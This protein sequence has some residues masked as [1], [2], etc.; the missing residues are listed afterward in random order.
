MCSFC[1]TATNKTGSD[2]NNSFRDLES[3]HERNV[4]IESLPSAKPEQLLCKSFI[5]KIIAAKLWWRVRTRFRYILLDNKIPFRQSCSRSICWSK[6]RQCPWLQVPNLQRACK[7]CSAAQEAKSD[8][9][10][11]WRLTLARSA[12][13]ILASCINLPVL[14]AAVNSIRFQEVK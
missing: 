14:P 3:I 9:Q 10:K 1:N 7:R 11:W 2:L 8:D 12:I 6:C 13:W 5:K 4:K